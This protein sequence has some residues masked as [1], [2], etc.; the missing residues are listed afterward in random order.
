MKNTSIAMAIILALLIFLNAKVDHNTNTNFE[1]ITG[2][3]ISEEKIANQNENIEIKKSDLKE[4]CSFIDYEGKEKSCFAVSSFSCD[5][6][7]SVC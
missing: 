4:C 1:D 6:C 2:Q 5:Y 3:V 7:S